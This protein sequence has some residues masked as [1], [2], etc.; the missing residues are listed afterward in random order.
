MSGKEL[1]K[2][3]ISVANKQDILSEL[4]KLAAPIRKA[5]GD[6]TPA[7]VQFNEV[8]GG[9]RA[10]SLEA[11]H[12]VRDR[13]SMNSSRAS[14]RRHSIH[15]RKRRNW[16]LTLRGRIPAWRR[17][18]RT[19]ENRRR[20]QIYEAGDGTRRQ[21]DRRE[22]YRDRGL[23]YRTTGDWQNCV[24]EYTQLVTRYPADRVGQN[25][26]ATCYAQ[27]RN[28]PKALAAA[29]QAVAI[30][31]KGVGPRLNLAFISSFAGDFQASEKK[32][33]PRWESIPMRRSDT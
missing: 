14:S 19:W 26:L 3:E 23:Y 11:V 32:R 4:P 31:P 17:W 27:L 9:F 13:L 2:A 5:L 21:H 15:S 7:S 6:N 20:H 33:K 24:Q 22:A 10:A 29:K 18:T 25:N 30:V 1:A 16:I 28:A 8:S 12:E